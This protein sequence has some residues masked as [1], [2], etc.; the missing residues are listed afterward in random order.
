M[1]RGFLKATV[2]EGQAVKHFATGFLLAFGAS[3]ATISIARAEILIGVPAP[4]TGPLSWLG[5]ST[6]RAVEMAAKHVNAAGGVLGQEVSFIIVDD[7]CDAEQA[8][9]AANKLVAEGV[10]LVLGYICSGA[11]IPASKIYAAA[12][13]LMITQS[14]TNPLLTEQG[15][16]NVFRYCGRDD[17]QGTIAGNYLAERWG[18]AYIAILHDGEAYGAGLAGETKKALN[19][20]GVREVMFEMIE[21]GL[22]D[23][24]DMVE[25]IQRADV[26]VLYYGG[27]HPE[28]ALLIRQLRARGDDLQFVS[29]DAIG[30]EDFGLIAREAAEGLLFTDFPDSRHLPKAAEVV[31]AFRADGFEATAGTL[32]SYGAIQAWAQAA[33]K[34]GTLELD[35]V[36]QSLR[37]NRFETIHGRIGFDEK[38]DVTG[39]EPFAWYVWK[40]GDYEPADPAELTE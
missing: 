24:F 27:Y 32:M 18:D 8:V 35:A 14:A 23:Y 39:Y 40:G 20:N 1:S 31:A 12:G 29:G 11:A 36:I 15:L 9:A 17:D 21:P 33:E 28:A 26:D 2:R 5:G 10:S 13:I 25:K 38:G 3:L 6:E 34:A 37:T 22:T 19:A 7:Y 30:T 4:Y 16:G